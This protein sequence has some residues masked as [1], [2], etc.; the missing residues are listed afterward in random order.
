MIL[1]NVM[2]PILAKKKVESE[3]MY[4]NYLK[5]TFR[6]FGYS[7]IFFSICVYFL[8]DFIVKILFGSDFN[9]ATSILKI[10][11]FTN[12]FIYMGIAQNLWVVNENKGKINVY[13]TIVGIVF[14]IG[15]NLLL[16]P[17]YG[18]IGAAYS[19]LIVQFISAFLINSIIAPEAFK[20]QWR[21]LL[22]R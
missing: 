11:V 13:K 16:I 14:A 19:A 3:V 18:L 12:V 9:E 10:H 5:L 4:Q 22:I 6:I 7:G 15:F 2:N 8:S 20:L 17:K 21:S 1:L